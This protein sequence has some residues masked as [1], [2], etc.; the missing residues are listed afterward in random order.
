MFPL[1]REF[2][3]SGE[4]VT[5]YNI[6]P[7]WTHVRQHLPFLIFAIFTSFG[8]I[9]IKYFWENIIDEHVDRHSAYIAPVSSCCA[10]KQ[11]RRTLKW[12]I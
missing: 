6:S 4:V 10:L 2:G 11:G 7:F 3:D 1:S 8:H 5:K 12:L 9:V